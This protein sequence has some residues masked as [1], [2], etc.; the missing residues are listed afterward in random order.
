[1]HFLQYLVFSALLFDPDSEERSAKTQLGPQDEAA[2]VCADAPAVWQRPPVRIEPTV[3]PT[4]TST[5]ERAS[6]YD[7][8]LFNGSLDESVVDNGVLRPKNWLIE[9]GARVNDWPPTTLP[10][11][12]RY[13]K[14]G[15]DG[16]IVL[17][18]NLTS[19]IYLAG[20]VTEELIRI[21]PGQTYTVGAEVEASYD[22]GHPDIAAG[23]GMTLAAFDKDGNHLVIQDRSGFPTKNA[24]EVIPVGNGQGWQRQALLT[25]GAPDSSS[26]Y[27]WPEGS[28]YFALFMYSN[29]SSPQNPT[30]LSSGGSGVVSV[31]E[32]FI[33]P[34]SSC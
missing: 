2:F 34:D 7:A 18:V 15:Q 8:E 30:N 3:T 19:L 26:K 16:V 29:L 33:T 27:V 6:C 21:D 10:L 31:R 13:E 32:V 11:D 12:A 14:R 28:A 24:G 5:P 20:V 4:A 25:I 22:F 1:M 17:D 9:R 23:I